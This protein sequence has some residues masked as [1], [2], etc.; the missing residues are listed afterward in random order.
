MSLT[1]IQITEIAENL[2]AGLHCHIDL[3]DWTIESIPDPKRHNQDNEKWP[4]ENEEPED[5]PKDN[6]RLL[7]LRG[8]PKMENQQIMHRFIPTVDSNTIQDQ[9]RSATKKKR[10]YKKF[11]DILYKFPTVQQE[12][13]DFNITALSEYVK[14]RMEEATTPAIVPTQF[15]HVTPV[16]PTADLDRDTHWYKTKL[17]FSILNKDHGYAVLRRR[18]LYIHLQWHA[19]TDEDPL[20]GGSVVKIF[21]KNIETLFAEF[22]EKEIISIDKLRKNTSWNTHEFGLYDLNG[23]AIFFVE[24]VNEIMK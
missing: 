2:D 12:W 9:L 23:N 19:N 20:L 5:S 7:I 14:R 1:T 13:F 3:N 17:G 6:R 4:T 10:A 8:V 16:L 18:D 24:D 15:L 22:V 21:V 11:K